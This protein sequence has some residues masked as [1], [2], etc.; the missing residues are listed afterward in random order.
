[1]RMGVLIGI[2][3]MNMKQEK[4]ELALFADLVSKSRSGETSDFSKQAVL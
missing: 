4:G 1:M 2:C 3:V